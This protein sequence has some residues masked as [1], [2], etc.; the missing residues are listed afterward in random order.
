MKQH[1]NKI[2]YLICF[3]P[4]KATN[5]GFKKNEFYIHILHNTYLCYKYFKEW[6]SHN[7][8]NV[9]LINLIASYA[10][11]VLQIYY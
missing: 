10:N 4:A 1:A 9:Y 6:L 3:T 11:A 7:Y 5:R 8:F 2:Y